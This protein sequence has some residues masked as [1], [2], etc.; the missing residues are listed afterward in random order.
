M[1]SLYDM[2]HRNECCVRHNV[3]TTFFFTIDLCD[4]GAMDLGLTGDTSSY[5]VKPL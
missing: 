5:T 1:P 3:N 2:G 4:L